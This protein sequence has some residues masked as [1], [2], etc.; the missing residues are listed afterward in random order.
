MIVDRKNLAKI[1]SEKV[2]YLISNLW[3]VNQSILSRKIISN[4]DIAS[5]NAIN[6][7]KTG[8]VVFE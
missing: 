8:F 3:Y 2:D 7:S 1:K 5:K 6:I 4:R